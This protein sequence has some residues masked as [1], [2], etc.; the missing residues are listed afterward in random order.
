MKSSFTSA[1]SA[2]AARFASTPESTQ[3]RSASSALGYLRRA[4]LG[5]LLFGGALFASP[6]VAQQQPVTIDK[7]EPTVFRVRTQNLAKEHGQVQ[8]Y[9]L[10]NGQKLFDEAFDQSYYS[11]RL[12][13]D[14]LQPGNYLLC[15][16]LGGDSYRYTLRVKSDG[17][18]E[19][20]AVRNVKV[21]LG[22]Q[23]QQVA[24]LN[25]AVPLAAT[26]PLAASGN[27]L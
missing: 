3:A 21:R 4:T 17:A 23:S 5:V 14:N 12:N 18:N 10:V 7:V 9:S 26:P 1:A 13:F 20:V 24:A 27:G 8:V 6:V 15:F 25:A 2:F 22:K 16:K 19:E 11:C